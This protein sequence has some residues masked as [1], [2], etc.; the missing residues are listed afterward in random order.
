LVP[1]NLQKKEL[2]RI[3]QLSQKEILETYETK[4]LTKDGSVID[5]L[6]TATGLI[7]QAGEVYAIATT[8]RH[9]KKS[10]KGA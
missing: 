9:Y 1:I 10:E 7:N 5:V 2:S 8:E 6:L 3:K 4:R